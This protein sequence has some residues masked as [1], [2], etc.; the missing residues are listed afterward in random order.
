[1]RSPKKPK[2]EA[3]RLKA[4]QALNILDTLPEPDFDEITFLASQICGTPVALISLVDEN[5][6]WFKSKWGLSGDETARDVSFCGHA[7]LESSPL[8]VADAKQDARFSDNPLVTGEPHVQFYAGAPLLSPDGFAIGTVCVIDSKPKN[9]SQDQVRALQT[10]SKQVTRILEYHQKLDELEFKNTA[11]NAVFDGIVLQDKEGRIINFN[12]AA[13]EVLSL[14]EAQLLG[15]SSLDPQWRCIRED[16]SPF[17]GQDHPAMVCLRTG[18]EQKNVL[19]GVQTKDGTRWIRIN[20]MPIFGKDRNTPIRAVTSFS[21]I[22]ARIEA[23]KEAQR[24]RTR[25]TQILD[26]VPM[27]VGHW[28]SDL[29]S[30]NSNKAYQEFFGL[31]ADQIDGMPMKKLLGEDV[32]RKNQPFIQEALAGK[33]P[34]FERRLKHADG[35]LHDTLVTYIP[36]FEDGKVASFLSVSTD[37]TELRKSEVERKALESRLSES[38]KL[39]ALGEMSAG[40]A[41]EI[42][43]PLAIIHGK[44]SILIQKIENESTSLENVHTELLKIEGNI[45]RIVRIVKALRTYSRNAENDEMKPVIMNDVFQETIELCHEKFQK[46]GIEIRLKCDPKVQILA[47]A[48]Q[49]SQALMNLLQNAYDAI[50]SLDEKWIEL[51]AVEKGDRIILSV[52]DSGNGIPEAITKKIM[53]PFFTTKEVGRGTG[54]GL[55]ITQGIAQSHNG[56]LVYDEQAKHTTFIL[57]LPSYNLPKTRQAA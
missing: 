13:L 54:L 2:N 40:I 43:N 15:R 11:A 17:P 16:G 29:Y 44:T 39:T 31:S 21:D 34:S 37:I 28:S 49:V 14:S 32:F 35:T 52:T 9:L 45:N 8:V 25:L 50:E 42:N 51:K 26:G 57:S 12:Q 36:Q 7:I 27:L 30:L 23:T 53:Q 38:A 19:M 6:Q 48:T 55:S 24:Q 10:L 1:M 41:H 22:T 33:R 46:A 56:T 4:L 47:R 5:R 18:Q 20:S 3:Q